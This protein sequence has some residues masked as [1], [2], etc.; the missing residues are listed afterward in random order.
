[1]QYAKMEAAYARM[2]QMTN[3]LDNFSQQNRGSR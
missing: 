3:S 1:M 2:E